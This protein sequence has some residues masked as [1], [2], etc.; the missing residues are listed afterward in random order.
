[1]FD[2]RH[3]KPRAPDRCLWRVLATIGHRRSRK[4]EAALWAFTV[5][6]HR[7]FMQPLPLSSTNDDYFFAQ[8]TS[9]P[10]RIARSSVKGH[11]DF[12]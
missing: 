7:D 11:E 8:A 12:L 1:M 4:F 5:E 9:M 3:S 2:G 6:R 10:T